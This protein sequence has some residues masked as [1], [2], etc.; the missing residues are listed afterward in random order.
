[1]AEKA[2][3]VDTW[4]RA[5]KNSSDLYRFIKFGLWD[6]PSIPFNEGEISSEILQTEREGKFGLMDLKVGLRSGMYEEIWKNCAVKKVKQVL[7]VLSTLTVWKG[8]WK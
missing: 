4:S 7:M 6:I 5:L 8:E 3:R 1:M 2:L